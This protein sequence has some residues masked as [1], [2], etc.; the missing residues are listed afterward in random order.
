MDTLFH[1]TITGY[2]QKH[3]LKFEPHW[4]RP[5]G[6]L[7]DPLFQ[8]TCRTMIY[9]SRQEELIVCIVVVGNEKRR[10]R[11]F[12]LAL[13]AGLFNYLVEWSSLLKQLFK[14]LIRT[15][16]VFYFLPTVAGEDEQVCKRKPQRSYFNGSFVIHVWWK[17]MDWEEAQRFHP[18]LVPCV[19]DKCYGK[20]WHKCSFQN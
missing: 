18:I 2:V 11:L 4:R 15:Q 19:S 17:K 8:A 3:G 9:I 12:F 7:Y 20:I 13:F 1:L 10:K 16:P 5:A 6:S 14:T